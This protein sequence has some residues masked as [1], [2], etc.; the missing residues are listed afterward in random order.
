MP[1]SITRGIWSEALLQEHSRCTAGET[2]R[3]PGRKKSG[4]KTLEESE[5][6]QR[7]SLQSRAAAAI[8][9][10]LSWTRSPGTARFTSAGLRQLKHTEQANA[11]ELCLFHERCTY[12]A[13]PRRQDAHPAT[14]APKGHSPS[15]QRMCV[16]VCARCRVIR[17]HS[18]R[19]E[20][21]IFL[22]LAVE[23]PGAATFDSPNRLQT[24]A[25]SAP[26]RS[27]HDGV[28][29]HEPEA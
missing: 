2:W 8:T 13:R 9:W 21:P 23:H 1:A 20:K 22:D 7:S 18:H 19:I 24:Q 10:K 11:S 15:A 14:V 27:C 29:G 5:D 4:E 3:N 12:D 25:E 6:L 16:C 17:I 26:R 28:E